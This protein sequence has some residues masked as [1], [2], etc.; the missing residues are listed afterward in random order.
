MVLHLN[1]NPPALGSLTIRTSWF[2][3]SEE[4]K[5]NFRVIYRDEKNCYKAVYDVGSVELLFHG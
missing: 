3:V 5:N 4:G 2:M 1:Y